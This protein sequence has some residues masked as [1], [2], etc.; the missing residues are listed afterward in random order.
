MR[1]LL[2]LKSGHNAG[3]VVRDWFDDLG[4]VEEF[5]DVFLLVH[6]LTFFLGKDISLTGFV[7]VLF[8]FFS[9]EGCS[10][11]EKRNFGFIKEFKSFLD[12]LN[13]ISDVDIL[14]V[15]GGLPVSNEIVYDLKSFKQVVHPDQDTHVFQAFIVHYIKVDFRILLELL[16]VLF[17]SKVGSLEP[18]KHPAEVNQIR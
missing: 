14:R 13:L 12:V 8:D 16:L 1:L 17:S 3:N 11:L 4:Y 6:E 2:L 18:L 15:S 10:L 5:L 9:Q 7:D